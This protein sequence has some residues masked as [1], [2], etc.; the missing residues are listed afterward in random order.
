LNASRLVFTKRT[1]RPLRA[2]AFNTMPSESPSASTKRTTFFFELALPA[3]NALMVFFMNQG[4]AKTQGPSYRVLRN[5]GHFLLTAP[6]MTFRKSL[7]KFRDGHEMKSA[8]LRTV[9]DIGVISS[10]AIAEIY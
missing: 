1:S 10:N 2:A 7:Q 8:T 4:C 3:W 9:S 5:M 6:C